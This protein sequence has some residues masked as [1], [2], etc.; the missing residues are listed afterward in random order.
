MPRAAIVAAGLAAALSVALPGGADAQRQ[1]AAGLVTP[2]PDP[3]APVA[4]YVV[5]P[6]AAPHPSRDALIRLLREK[7]KYVFVIFNENH[8][9]DNEFGTFPGVDGLYSD[10]T[11][12]RSAADT[13]GFT[14]SYKDIN[15]TNVTVQPFLIGAGQNA[16]FVDSVDHSHKGLAAKL[17]VVD[18]VPRMDGFSAV[19]YQ[20]YARAGNNL[21][22]AQGMQFARL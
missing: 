17:H 8:S 9:F 11:K 18:G 10:G 15:G 13:P 6:A 19:E 7:I 4:P 22:Q 1:P 2:Q 3:G 20:K 12:P 14:E 5:D 16:S 21:S